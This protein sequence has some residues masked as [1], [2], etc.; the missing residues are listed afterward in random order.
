MCKERARERERKG[1][2]TTLVDANP[3]L[4]R[5]SLSALMLVRCP[6]A[7]LL[8]LVLHFGSATKWWLCIVC[9]FCYS[10]VII[11]PQKNCSNVFFF[12]LKNCSNVLAYKSVFFLFSFL[13]RMFAGQSACMIAIFWVVSLQLIVQKTSKFLWVLNS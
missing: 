4:K 12:W 13:L 8:P 6:R 3:C 10:V 1:K 2:G 11:W 5:F 9:H 7:F